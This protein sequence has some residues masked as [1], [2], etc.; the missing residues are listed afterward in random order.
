M[1][2]KQAIA[3]AQPLHARGAFP[4]VSKWD[5]FIHNVNQAFAEVSDQP[6]KPEVKFGRVGNVRFY[7]RLTMVID[8]AFKYGYKEYWAVKDFVEKQGHRVITM[9]SILSLTAHEGTTSKHM[10]PYKVI[11]LQCIGSAQWSVWVNGVENKYVLN[12]GDFIFVPD[13]L[14]HEVRSL[15]PRTALSFMID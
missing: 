9:M 3:Q 7:D 12:P 5:D 11:Y 15:S 8:Y 4:I 14:Q 10:D 1:D 6:E 13:G 2:L